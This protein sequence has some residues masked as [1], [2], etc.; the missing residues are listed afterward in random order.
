MG[1]EFCRTSDFPRGTLYRLLMDGY[2]FD[3]RYALR[4][5]DDWR[6][7]DDFFYDNLQIADTCGFITTHN[8]EPVGFVSW[9][10]RSPGHTQIGHN[11]VAAQ[12]KGRGY[13]KAQM[14]EAVDRIVRG[15][16]KKI[17]VT[18]DEAL[19]AAQRM[20][21]SVGFAPR[22]R[23]KNPDTAEFAGGLIDYEYTV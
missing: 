20:Y 16:V 22:Q 8:G 12:Y 2:S 1:I 14:R 10:P 23:R 3:V 17:I 11:C 6:E 19:L 5:Q 15:G 13:G 9:D 21:E 7:F 4:F 18:T